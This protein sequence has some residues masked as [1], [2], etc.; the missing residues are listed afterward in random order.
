M[1]HRPQVG[2]IFAE[3][4]KPFSRSFF[5]PKGGSRSLFFVRLFPF[6]VGYLPGGAIASKKMTHYVQDRALTRPFRLLG[7][8]SRAADC[9]RSRWRAFAVHQ[10]QE[11]DK[12]G[13]WLAKAIALER[14]SPKSK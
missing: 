7:I 3:H 9:G 1:F 12:K 4:V 14:L 8:A 10:R 5:F 2:G 6:N 13:K 11:R